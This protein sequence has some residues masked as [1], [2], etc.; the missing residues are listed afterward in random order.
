MHRKRRDSVN[1]QYCRNCHREYPANET[2]CPVC[3]HVHGTPGGTVPYT[4]SAPSTPRSQDGACL[5]I[6]D[7]RGIHP[8]SLG[9]FSTWMLGR[10]GQ[11][12]VPQR[13]GLY[14]S[15][16][17]REHGMF[18]KSGSDWFY[19]DSPKNTNGTYLNGKKI[20]RPQNSGQ[21]VP[22]RLADGDVLSINNSASRDSNPH[23]VLMVFSTAF[24]A[25]AIEEYDLTGK[26][27]VTIGRASDSNVVLSI[28]YISGKHAMIR[29]N[30]NRFL[31]SDRQSKSGTFV[32]HKRISG[33]VELREKD[34]FQLCDQKFVLSC[35]K[36]YYLNG[37]S[38]TRQLRQAAP[39]TRP[40]ALRADIE[41]KQVK[42]VNGSGTKELIRDIHLTIREGTLVAMLGTAGA[43][44]STV[45][46][47]LNGM[48]LTGVRGSVYYR[49]VNLLEHFDQMK[50]L[51]GSVPQQKVF[52][53]TFTPEQEFRFA[54][55][56]RLPGD[57]SAAEINKRV[58]DTLNMLSIQGVRNNRNSK[59]SGGEQTRVN[60]GIELV[61][62][63]DFLCLDEPDQGLSPNYK[64]E[65]FEILKRLARENGK[66]VLCIIHDVSEIDMFDQVIILAKKDGVGRLAFSG[67]PAEA[68]QK[69]NAEIRDVYTLL[70]K[71][72]ERYIR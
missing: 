4:P 3:G 50:E 43:G 62:D 46:N 8:F 45:M 65:L 51:I 21:M 24:I 34:S 69:F 59:L 16:V 58:N 17:S 12:A 10:Q 55:I 48:D 67:S 47:C 29:R 57:T 41:T 54:A 33:E 52:H 70:D 9:T 40:I 44:K 11:D 37:K 14:S 38:V 28:P 15:I 68:R 32:N 71:H 63:R 72:P 23:A 64:H 25:G 56:K 49:N 35:N 20:P 36:L 66:C 27:V 26:T 31:L 39:S 22:Y 19:L 18:Q 6:F 60:I 5:V 7:D 1:K 13:I 53:K 2:V 30:G 61:A 42:N